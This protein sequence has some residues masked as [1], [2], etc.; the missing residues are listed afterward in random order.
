VVVKTKNRGGRALKKGFTVFTNDPANREV[1][2][3]VA[4]KVKGYVSVAPRSIRLFGNAGLP[5]SRTVKIL[6]VDGHQFSI[7]EVTAH[8][9]KYLQYQVKPM[10]GASG[11]KGYLLLVENTMKEPGKY[12]DT[13]LIKTDSRKKPELRIPVYCRIKAPPVPGQRTKND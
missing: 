3:K 6:P 9:D 4:G 5:L 13:I 12:R 1:K 11:K 8:T 10:D 7:K 2:L